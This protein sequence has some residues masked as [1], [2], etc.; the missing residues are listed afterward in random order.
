MDRMFNMSIPNCIPQPLDKNRH[1][2]K[3]I[4]INTPDFKSHPHIFYRT[5]PVYA[6]GDYSGGQQYYATAS[7]NFAAS[8][9]SSN[10]NG[11]TNSYTHIVPVDEAILGVNQSRGSPQSI[12]NVSQTFQINLL[13]RISN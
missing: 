5:Y 2:C 11:S 8:S 10:G 9:T 6:V 4:T 1:K 12:S 13:L 7:S 3:V